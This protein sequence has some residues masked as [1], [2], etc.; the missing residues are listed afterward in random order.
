M[1]ITKC[2]FILSLLPTIQPKCNIGHFAAFLFESFL[3]M[4]MTTASEEMVVSVRMKYK[5]EKE[6]IWRPEFER[7]KIPA[8]ICFYGHKNQPNHNW[9]S[10][11]CYAKFSASF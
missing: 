8:L 7:E 1:M 10:I 2:T 4:K 6:K 9:M 5:E 3:L 11:V